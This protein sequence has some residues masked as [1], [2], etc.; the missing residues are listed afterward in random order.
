[1]DSEILEELRK[2]KVALD[3]IATELD[4][5][6]SRSFSNSDFLILEFRNI[7]KAFAVLASKI[8]DKSP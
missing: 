7:A 2:L 6:Q 8:S 5:Q 4:A 3:G 1:M